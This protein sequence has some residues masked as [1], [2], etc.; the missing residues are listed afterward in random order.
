MREDPM[1]LNKAEWAHRAFI[2]GVDTRNLLGFGSVGFCVTFYVNG[3][4]FFIV[5]ASDRT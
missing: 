1:L 5:R 4:K 2:Q 3:T